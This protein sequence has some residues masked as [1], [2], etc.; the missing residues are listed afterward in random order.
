MGRKGKMPPRHERRSLRA[1]PI[2]LRVLGWNR[3]VDCSTT[4]GHVCG[5]GVAARRPWT[6]TPTTT[7]NVP[8]P[9]IPVPLCSPS[10]EVGLQ[11]P[12]REL[13]VRAP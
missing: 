10:H 3:A 2:P 9:H 11:T 12:Q 5:A 1:P 4:G 7:T 6:R 13:E 8:S